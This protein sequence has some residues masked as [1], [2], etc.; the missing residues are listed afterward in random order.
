MLPKGIKYN[1]NL[2]RVKIP[3]RYSYF[4]VVVGIAW[5]YDPEGCVG[6]SI[7]TGIYPEPDR[8]TVIIQAKTGL[9]DP[10]DLVELTVDNP[11]L[12][13]ALLKCL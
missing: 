8:T 1:C 9:P 11:T 3:F 2:G 6:G 12:R 10:P 5:P 4:D 7:T 13:K